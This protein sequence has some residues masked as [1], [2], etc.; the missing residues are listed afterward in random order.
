MRLPDYHAGLILAWTCNGM[1]CFWKVVFLDRDSHV[2]SPE[3]IQGIWILLLT[4]N[5]C[6]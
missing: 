3:L 2:I 5:T 6:V 4:I 1:D